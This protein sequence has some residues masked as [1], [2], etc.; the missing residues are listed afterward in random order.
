MKKILLVL[1]LYLFI[2]NTVNAQCAWVLWERSD[3]DAKE[4]KD[5]HSGSWSIVAAFPTANACWQEE[6]DICMRLKESRSKNRPD[7]NPR[8]KLENVKC[9]KS[10]GG[11]MLTWDNERG[12]GMSTYKCFPDTV[13][14]RK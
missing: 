12:S 3:F 7:Q 14:P 10:W 5:S 11:H 1:L 9:F 4:T 2:T 13:D 8:F 6:E